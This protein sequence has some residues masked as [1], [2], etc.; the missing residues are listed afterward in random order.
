MFRDIRV[1]CTF[2]S[3]GGYLQYKNNCCNLTRK[4]KI[5]TAYCRKTRRVVGCVKCPQS[6]DV[7]SPIY[8][9][10]QAFRLDRRVVSWTPEA[11]C[12]GDATPRPSPSPSPPLTRGR[13]S[14]SG[15]KPSPKVK[16]RRLMSMTKSNRCQPIVTMTPTSFCSYSHGI[17]QP[18]WRDPRHFR[19]SLANWPCVLEELSLPK[20]LKKEV[21]RGV[22]AEVVGRRVGMGVGRPGWGC[23]VPSGVGHL[24]GLPTDMTRRRPDEGEGER[25]RWGGCRRGGWYCWCGALASPGAGVAGGGETFVFPEIHPFCQSHHNCH[26]NVH[27][28]HH[29]NWWLMEFVSLFGTKYV[30]KFSDLLYF[31]Q[32]LV[33]NFSQNLVKK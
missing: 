15:Q 4:Y 14:Q 7:Y 1:I 5:F 33:Q 27:K 13:G 8:R 16:V 25:R 12:Q 18:S 10:R 20:A 21:E 31:S 22:V 3:W 17:V 24:D 26:Q 23:Q 19:Q 9:T 30:T 6:I 2:G 32:I 28:I 29:Q 11:F